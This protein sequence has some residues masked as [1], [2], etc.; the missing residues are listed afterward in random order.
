MGL[1]SSSF[2]PVG[3]PAQWSYTN[4]FYMTYPETGKDAKLNVGRIPTLVVYH[5]AVATTGRAV[6]TLNNLIN[7][8][9]AAEMSYLSH[10]HLTC[11][12]PNDWTELLTGFNKILSTEAAF[13][14]AV[15]QITKVDEGKID[16][17]SDISKRF[18]NILKEEAISIV[19]SHLHSSP[20]TLTI[21]ILQQTVN[22]LRDFTYVDKE[23]GK[24]TKP[25][26]ELY[27]VIN[28]ATNNSFIQS[29]TELIK[30]EQFI[31]D[32]QQYYLNGKQ[33]KE[34]SLEITES[35]YKI[36]SS[37]EEVLS[38]VTAGELARLHGGNST[39]IYSAE[40]PG[41]QNFKPDVNLFEA[42][43]SFS[44]EDAN[45]MNAGKNHKSSKRIQGFQAAE[46]W[47]N[48]L[49]QARGDLVIISNKNYVINEMLKNGG[50]YSNGAERLPGFS[51][52]SPMSILNFQNFYNEIGGNGLDVDQL[53]DYLANLGDSMIL[54][55]QPNNTILKGLSS[56]LGEFLFDDLT[57]TPPA[58]LNV[59]HVFRLSGIY[60]P[61]SLILKS[62]YDAL[63]NSM[64]ELKKTV[65]VTFEGGNTLPPTD[66]KQ[67]SEG[68]FEKFRNAKLKENKIKVTFL[69]D[70]VNIIAS[71]VNI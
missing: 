64:D 68:K 45:R 42:T 39:V 65:T 17:Y 62:V 24:V 50:T 54:G 43:Y 32:L 70:F 1:E 6:E 14:Y 26:Y 35:Y 29:M 27:N 16:K 56:Q 71:K 9:Q 15:E 20:K 38:Q 11:G 63:N 44:L 47:F 57:I 23:T 67:W 12:N 19:S 21:E 52:Q 40:N 25:F 28:V 60:V 53:V 37:I 61:L 33:G 58:N 8:A 36:D 69:S 66:D 10:H 49:K 48:Q 51:A 55:N 41:P 59:V 2:F 31:K 18:R 3:G 22:R 5:N 30:I 46:T 34:P 13:K 4:D 7:I